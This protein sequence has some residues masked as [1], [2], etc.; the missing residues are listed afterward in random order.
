MEVEASLSSNVVVRASLCFALAGCGDRPPADTPA[1]S[2]PAGDTA[3]APTSVATSIGGR[4]W[5]LVALGEQASPLGAGGKPATI[6]FDSAASRAAGFAGC[7]RFSGS[8]TLGPDSLSFGP[9]MSTKMACVDGDALERG[10]LA[11]LSRVTT[12]ILAD[13]TLTLGTSD[14]PLLRFQ[15]R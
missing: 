11:A 15:A 8:Y 3:V 1:A 7:N 10:F 4:E 13:S 9:V 6:Q 12:Y 14:G 5:V 2:P